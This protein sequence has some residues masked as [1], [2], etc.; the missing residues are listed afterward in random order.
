MTKPKVKRRGRL[1][2]V[3]KADH[4][5]PAEVPTISAKRSAKQAP[6]GSYERYRQAKPGDLVE[7]ETFPNNRSRE[8][9]AASYNSLPE[10]TIYLS[11]TERPEVAFMN[12]KKEPK[13]QQGGIDEVV[14]VYGPITGPT[15]GDSD[16]VIDAD[17]VEIPEDPTQSTHSLVVL[18]PLGATPLP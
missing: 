3:G 16:D 11:I 15:V 12:T 7:V 18:G 14:F 6:L 8:V 17:F 9:R 13:T 10:N 4:T 5:K 2:Q 1:K